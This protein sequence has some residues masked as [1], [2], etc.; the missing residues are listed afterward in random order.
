MSFGGVGFASDPRIVGPEVARGRVDACRL[1]SPTDRPDGVAP[2]HIAFRFGADARV[3]PPCSVPGLDVAGLYVFPAAGFRRELAS[4]PGA[5]RAL[6]KLLAAR[7]MPAGAELPFVPFI[8]ASFAV[9]TRAHFIDFQGGSGV[10][11][12]A[13]VSTE[14]DD[15]G[16]EL[17]F[18]FQ[19]LSADGARY[20]LGIFPATTGVPPIRFAVDPHA[21]ILEQTAA[22]EPYRRQVAVALAAAGDTA[23]SPRPSRLHA[24]LATLS[25]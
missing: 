6:E 7:A 2:E 25:L 4:A 17:V 12:L 19:G 1:K 8:D 21:P 14:P 15:L 10:L 20:V 16:D 9:A 22:F 24:M 3:P 13:E 18:V 5:L 11:V 23:F